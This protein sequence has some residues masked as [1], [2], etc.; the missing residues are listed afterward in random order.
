LEEFSPREYK[1]PS[2]AESDISLLLFGNSFASSNITILQTQ[3]IEEEFYPQTSQ[4]I[5]NERFEFNDGL[6]FF[7]CYF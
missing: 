6:R 1:L 4:L 7:K 5:Y 2:I 3:Q